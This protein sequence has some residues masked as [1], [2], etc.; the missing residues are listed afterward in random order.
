MRSILAFGSLPVRHKV[1]LI[2]AVTVL[3]VVVMMVLYLMTIR[4]LLAV[5]EEVERILA[6]HLHTR[7][8]LAQVVDVQDGFRGFVLTRNET[9]LAPYYS[10]EESL[11]PSI[12]RLK[13]MIREDEALLRRVNETE[14]HIRAL[15]Q[16]KQQL[17]N[18]VR[19][20]QMEPAQAHIESGEGQAA[21]D[22]IRADLTAFED[23][24]RLILKDRQAR[25]NRLAALAVYGLDIGIAGLVGILILWWLGG[26]LLARTITGPIAALTMAAHGLGSGKPLSPIPVASSDELGVLARTMEEMERRIASDIAQMEALLAIGGDV[27]TIGPDG[28]EGVLERIA[29][30]AGG[31]L[32]V[33][34][35][36]VLLWDKTTECWKVG[37]A[38]GSWH[39]LL[40]GSVL[41]R[42]ETP[43]CYRALMTGFP[44]IVEDLRSRP[45]PVLQVRDRLGAR[46]LLAVPLRGQGGAFGVLSLAPTRAQRIF[47]E[48]DVRLARQFA[49]QAAIAILNAHLYEDSRQRGEGLQSRL[50]Q[51]ERYAANM[52]HD[53]KGPA[54]RMAELAS[55]LQMD[56]KGRWDERADRYLSWMRENGQQLMSRIEEVLKL[57][58]IGTVHETVEAVDPLE[59]IRDVMK[60]CAEDIERLGARICIAERFPRLACN[61]VHLFQV[62]DN[63]VR[64]AMQYT[65]DGRAPEIQIGVGGAANAPV[66][67]VK[68]NGIGIAPSGRERIF[69]PFERLDQNEASG[70]GIGLAIVKKIVDLYQG[71]VWVESEPGVGSAFFFTLP[72]YGELAP[73]REEQEETRT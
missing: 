69:E 31:V 57:A 40:R 51:L 9:F 61:R 65:A 20:G 8:I 55:L 14:K 6:V 39:D 27:L 3:P 58:R 63:L 66:I 2:L 54:R 1:T 48:W 24:Q 22:R 19:V 4:Q 29:E 64:N 52:A 71:R 38:S 13:E 11:D 43:I 17:I 53:L 45:E 15:L 46:S 5:Q 67:F 50:L 25:A 28:L 41:I 7:T 21:L 33:D 10:A 70:T 62:M 44:Q 12:H 56:Y 32:N 73:A 26:L 47:T 68:D 30:R 60:S 59:V 35:C 49:D 34:L 16:K 23:V 18:A 36:L 42:E 37:A 72:P